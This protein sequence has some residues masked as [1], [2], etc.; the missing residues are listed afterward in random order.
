LI[1]AKHNR[2]HE[3]RK[4]T[5]FTY[6]QQN[7]TKTQNIANAKPRHPQCLM[8]INC[9]LFWHFPSLQNAAALHPLGHIFIQALT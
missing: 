3:E 4:A 9:L 7:I 6:K 8:M 1:N 2:N 5:L